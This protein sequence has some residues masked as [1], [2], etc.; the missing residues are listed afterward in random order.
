MMSA[1]SACGVELGLLLDQLAER[2]EGGVVHLVDLIVHG[3]HGRAPVR[4]RLR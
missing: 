3:E 4:R 1:L 2:V